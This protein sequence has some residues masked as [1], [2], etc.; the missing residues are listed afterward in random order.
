MKFFLTLFATILLPLQSF[1]WGREGHHIVA[2]I[3]TYYLPQAI[4]E[5][6]T[7]ELGSLS[8]EDAATWMDDTR[9]SGEFNYMKPWHYIN[10]PQ[11]ETYKPGQSDNIITAL[12][13][14]FSDIYLKR[15]DERQRS[16]DLWILFHLIG[17]IHQ[18]LHAGYGEDKGGNSVQ[19]SYGGNATNLH[20]IWDGDII[21]SQRITTEGCIA[22]MNS[23]P[24]RAL[25][26]VQ[27][28]NFVAW[29]EESRKLLPQVYDFS[30]HLI[31]SDYMQKNSI[32]VKTQL[33]RAGIRLAYVL[34]MLYGTDKAAASAFETGSE[35]ISIGSGQEKNHSNDGGAIVLNSGGTYTPEQAKQHIGEEITV[36]GKVY[37]GKYLKSSEV[38]FLN[39]GAA[40]PANPLTIVIF[41]QDRA[42]F[43]TPPERLYDGLNICV[44]GLIK[45]YKGKAEIIVAKEEQIQIQQAFNK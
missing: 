10:I 15:A 11:G 13:H 19:V 8:P 44:M 24:P 23:L 12:N 2:E 35:E 25:K 3:A 9:S 31:D 26:A 22:Y 43:T 42:H 18:P 6:V 16:Q 21:S 1:S 14:A 4:R 20:H 30:G 17:D 40:Y 7:G 36:C 32:V 33:L 41:G 5:K 37:G 39:I 29:M 28:G 27:S 38:T 45:D 34:Q